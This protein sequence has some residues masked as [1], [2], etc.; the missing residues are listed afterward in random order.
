[1]EKPTDETHL[2]MKT[3]PK[4]IPKA[5]VLAPPYTAPA[6]LPAR[7]HSKDVVVTPT[8]S[9]S[10]AVVACAFKKSADVSTDQLM[11]VPS[12]PRST[13]RLR[14]SFLKE[15]STYTARRN[16]MAFNP[17]LLMDSIDAPQF[18]RRSARL[19]RKSARAREWSNRRGSQV[20]F[21]NSDDSGVGPTRGN[22][23][24]VD[25]QQ[26]EGTLGLEISQRKSSN[27]SGQE[28]FPKLNKHISYQYLSSS[29]KSMISTRGSSRISA[30]KLIK[31]NPKMSISMHPLDAKSLRGLER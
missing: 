3:K 28:Q 14:S 12:S 5:L 22:L 25:H 30:H 2:R 13:L 1:M 27:S 18:A 6:E 21:I 31:R 15:M 29:G 23:A 9:L 8:K 17:S 4:P 16:S 24:V 10:M 7:K 26:V 20:H 19:R 11:P